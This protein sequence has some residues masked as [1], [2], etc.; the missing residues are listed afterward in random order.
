MID[1]NIKILFKYLEYNNI[2]IDTDEF[3][4][5]LQGHPDFPTLLSY[6]DTLKFFNIEN[7][8]YQVEN[9]EIDLLPKNFIALSEGEFKFIENK[10]RDSFLSD[11]DNVVL[12]IDKLK[13]NIG[14]KFRIPLVKIF[15]VIVVL[16]ILLLFHSEP[17]NIILKTI[18]FLTTTVGLILAFEAYRKTHGKGTTIPLGVCQNKVLKTDCDFVFNTKQ[19]SILKY[20]DL[21]E[22]SI[23]FFATQLSC[24]LL[25]SLLHQTETLFTIYK[26]GLLLFAPL[27]LLSIYYQVFTVNK[28]CPICIAIII[29]VTIQI[30]ALYLLFSSENINYT[31]IA[32][33]FLIFAAT[34]FRLY[35]LKMKFI[36][37]QKLED[38]SRNYFKFRKN[39][40]FFKNNLSIQNELLNKDFSNAFQFGNRNSNINITLITNPFCKHCKVFYPSFMRIV[41][42]LS[43]KISINVIL[44][45]DLDMQSEE[46]NKA[47]IELAEIY[48]N[49][50]NKI[51]FLEA[52]NSWYILHNG[53]NKKENWYSKY[54]KY[55]ENKEKAVAI[56]KNQRK[57][58]DE[59]K[60]YYT[61]TIFINNLEYPIEYERADIE[62][63]V[64]EIIEEAENF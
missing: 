47:Y 21:S 9:E 43:E 41:N 5:Q 52:L 12:V 62:Y 39:F 11:W 26:F 27:A 29:C 55:F 31:A 49:A 15:S 40:T 50:E 7:I 8:S 48:N 44:D 13:E 46:S 42:H 2:K 64:S 37:F 36:T 53:T 24:L 63:F 57:W 61:P 18:F 28:L 51:E 56:L 38:E 20:V 58:L 6:S 16:F 32:F 60:I 34:V 3:K 19:W 14:N 45:A 30:G 25:L 10:E 59:N 4:L 35:Y 23:V 54:S 33:C 22:V 17:T 1:K